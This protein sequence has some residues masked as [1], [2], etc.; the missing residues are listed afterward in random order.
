M[1]SLEDIYARMAQ[2]A[3]TT[4][5]AHFVAEPAATAARGD[6]LWVRQAGGRLQCRVIGELDLWSEDGLVLSPQ[7]ESTPLAVAAALLSSRIIGRMSCIADH[8]ESLPW[9]D[10]GPLFATQLGLLWRRWE[11]IP[12]RRQTLIGAFDRIAAELYDLSLDDLITLE[13]AMI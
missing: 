1:P 10:I 2:R 5:G 11:A 4:L 9:P 3:P 12:D 7:V 8:L 13:R 6:V